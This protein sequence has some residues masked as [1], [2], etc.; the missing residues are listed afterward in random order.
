M[1]HEVAERAGGQYTRG[2]NQTEPGQV[3]PSLDHGVQEEMV[4]LCGAA[5]FAGRDPSSH[6]R[7]RWLVSIPWCTRVGWTENWHRSDT[8]SRG[9]TSTV[10]RSTT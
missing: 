5:S 9:G 10:V 2:G 8:Q 4:L 3:G 1:W 7:D 6:Y